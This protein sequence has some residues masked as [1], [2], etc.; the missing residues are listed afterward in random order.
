[1]NNNDIK[2]YR[3]NTAIFKI[4]V[5]ISGEPYTL[6][7]GDFIRFSVKSNENNMLIEKFLINADYDDD[8]ELAI[9]F[10]PEDTINMH[11]GSYFYDCGL[12]LANGEFYTFISKSS[13]TILETIA[14]RM[15]L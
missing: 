13:F 4:G 15:V 1:M 3:G 8:G 6:Q 9:K 12:Q 7:D 2:I 11:N 14:E 5:N 10:N